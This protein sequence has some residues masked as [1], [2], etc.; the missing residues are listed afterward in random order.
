SIIGEN[1]IVVEGPYTL[2][3]ELVTPDFGYDFSGDGAPNWPYDET[4]PAIGNHHIGHTLRCVTGTC[5]G[6]PRHIAY[7]RDNYLECLWTHR[8]NATSEDAAVGSTYQIGRPAVRIR[9][10]VGRKLHGG[11]GAT[12][13]FDRKHY[14]ARLELKNI[15]LAAPE[16]ETG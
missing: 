16:G 12:L 10:D 3:S 8:A 15:E 9:F 5:A 13:R 7:N 14:Q 6:Q 4:N 11:Q 2:N 1:S